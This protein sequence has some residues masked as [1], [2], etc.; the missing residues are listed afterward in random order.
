MG[1]RCSG[2]PD[3]NDNL[4]R[5]YRGDAAA[6]G[7]PLRQR[8]RKGLQRRQRAWDRSEL[9]QTKL[10]RGPTSGELAKCQT[11]PTTDLFDEL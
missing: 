10:G 2:L 4:H 8:G 7:D 1:I 3:S 6:A 5:D 9:Q 11:V